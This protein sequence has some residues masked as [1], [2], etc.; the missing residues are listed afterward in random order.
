[1][2]V[3]VPESTP[4]EELS[5]MPAGSVDPVENVAVPC[6]PVCVKVCEYGASTVALERPGFVTVMVWQA[7]VSV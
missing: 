5:V 3:G 7:I 4:V 6:A 2:T 1:M